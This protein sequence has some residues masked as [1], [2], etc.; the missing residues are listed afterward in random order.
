MKDVIVVQ[1]VGA[2]GRFVLLERG[3][4]LDKQHI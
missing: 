3:L 2:S 1:H 4:N